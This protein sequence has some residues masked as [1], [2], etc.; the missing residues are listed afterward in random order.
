MLCSTG[1]VLQKRAGCRW[2]PS[3]PTVYLARYPMLP[4][5][6]QQD[7]D[8]FMNALLSGMSATNANDA[9]K[10]VQRPFASNPSHPTVT[11]T[12]T[13]ATT[14]PSTS[15]PSP[16]RQ[17]TQKQILELLDG[18]EDWSWDADLESDDLSTSGSSAAVSNHNVQP[19]L[20]PALLSR[21]S[22]VISC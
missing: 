14:R 7:E 6:I 4:I 2:I 9:S 8:D 21:F 15:Q 3:T 18:A 20:Q 12:S 17:K 1:R 19:S 16:T 22:R 10:P 11:A 5:T 13:T